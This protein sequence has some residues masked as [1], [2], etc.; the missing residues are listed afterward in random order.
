[1]LCIKCKAWKGELGL[2][3]T[4]D[5]F[6]NNLCD[7]FDEV[8]RVLQTTR[9]LLGKSGIYAN[10]VIQVNKTKVGNMQVYKNEVI[11]NY[12]L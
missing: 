5:M 6:I 3:P 4:P 2:E 10:M 12:G 7:I 8:K 9:K 1:M 11:S